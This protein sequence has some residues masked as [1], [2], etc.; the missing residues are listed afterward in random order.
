MSDQL[1]KGSDKKIKKMT[2]QFKEK[3]IKNEE[4]LGP[5]ARDEQF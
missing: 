5:A 2:K 4:K 1:K 3:I